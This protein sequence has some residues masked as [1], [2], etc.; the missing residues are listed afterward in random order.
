MNKDRFTII[1]REWNL[2]LVPFKE[3]KG[4]YFKEKYYIMPEVLE[5]WGF[6]YGYGSK[7]KDTTNLIKGVDFAVTRMDTV[8]HVKIARGAPTVHMKNEPVAVLTENG[9]KDLTKRRRKLTIQQKNMVKEFSEQINSGKIIKLEEHSKIVRDALKK[10]FP[11][12]KFKVKSRP[13]E[14]GGNVWVYHSFLQ[15]SSV[16]HP[17]RKEIEEFIIRFNGKKEDLNKE[18]YNVGFMHNGERLIGAQFISY[19]G[20]DLHLLGDKKIREIA[21][22]VFKK[23]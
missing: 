12:I 2:W 8:R 16:F 1:M 20:S 18:R 22:K 15:T 19:H 3:S 13:S 4:T 7:E 6:E 14:Y 9:K 23:L 17:K 5:L 10:E 11:D 21:E